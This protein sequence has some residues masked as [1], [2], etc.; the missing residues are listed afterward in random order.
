MTSVNTKEKSAAVIRSGVSAQQVQKRM[1]LV[2]AN[3]RENWELA[4]QA[5][6][7]KSQAEPQETE[8]SAQSARKLH[9]EDYTALLRLVEAE[10]SGE[11]IR[12]KMLVANVVLNRVKS[13][14]FPDTVR[15]VI[16]QRNGKTAQFS[17]VGSGKIDRVKVSRETKLAVDRVLQGEDESQGALYFVARSWADSENRQWFDKHLTLLFA[18]RGHEFFA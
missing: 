2:N 15:E 4:Q 9:K 16:Y 14:K 11:D 13:G 7:K 10:A 17:P 5:V 6:L 8:K 18:Y 1:Q 12:G 3:E